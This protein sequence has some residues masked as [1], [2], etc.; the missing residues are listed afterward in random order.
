MPEAAAPALT[1]WSKVATVVRVTSGNFLEMFDFFLFGVYASHIASAF[2]P[3]GSEFASLMLTFG[4]FAIGFLMRPL[5]AIVLG[6]Y[7]DRV[8]RRRG[9]ITTLSIMAA[10]T[11][12]IAFTPSYAT[13]GIAAPALVVAGRLLQGF[14]AGVELG[15]VSVYLSEIATPGR[16]GFY[17][18]WQSASQQV[19]IVVATA[20]GFALQAGM[21]PSTVAAWGWRIPFFVGC[22]II[23][24]IFVIRRSL[25]ETPAFLAHRHRPTLRQILGSLVEHWF[26]VLG[27]TLLVVMTTVSFYLITVYTPTFGKNV[28]KLGARDSLLVTSCVGLSNLFWLP[29]MGALSDRIGRRPLLVGCTLLTILTSYAAMSWLVAAPSLPRMLLVE[30]WLSVLYASYNGAMI[31]TLTEVMPTEVRTTGFSLAYSLATTLGG[32]T[33]AIS[34]WLIDRLD[35]KA[36]PALWMSFSAVCGLAGTLMLLSRRRGYG[37]SSRSGRSA[38]T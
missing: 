28:L 34:T 10:G 7:V 11:M 3:A 36:A 14:S 25:Q 9:L 21:A 17:V 27:G 1:T 13:I 8:G 23:P 22:L 12:L 16:K 37:A 18:S 6:A 4:T 5:G 29:V 26:V 19:A 32:S 20:L 31:V 33:L 24:V 30:L 35:N 38:T 15:G 2:F